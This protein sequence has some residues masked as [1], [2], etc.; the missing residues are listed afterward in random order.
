MAYMDL[1]RALVAN[2]G[3]G[4]RIDDPGWPFV[5]QVDLDVSGGRPAVIA[6]SVESR[7]GSPITSAVLSQL[8][9]RQL[10]SV[11]ASVTAGEGEAHYRMLARPRSAGSRWSPE[12]FARVVKV[13][14]WATA[15][16]RPGG[17]AGAVAEFWSVHPR[18]AQRWIARGTS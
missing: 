18:T 15:T 1:S 17:A 12:H 11:T 10:A 6:L 3:E 14:A 2:L 5:V 4:V 13:A 16:G 8:P 7:D 9:M